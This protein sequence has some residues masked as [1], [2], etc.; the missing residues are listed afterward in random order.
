[1]DLVIE[2]VMWV[3]VAPILEFLITGI[4]VF[5]AKRW[6]WHPLKKIYD[7]QATEAT[8]TRFIMMS[9]PD[10]KS[11][12]IFALVCAVLGFILGIAIFPIAYASKNMSLY[13]FIFAEISYQ[14]VVLPM[15]LCALHYT[16]KK[17]YFF[18]NDIIIK[19]FVYFKRVSFDTIITVTENNYT[20][21][22]LMLVIIYNKKRKVKINQNFVNYDLAKKRFMDMQLIK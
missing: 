3:V 4:V 7:K 15:L 14:V 16:T 5:I 18:E 13:D 9:N 6:K 2:I 19:S 21:I 22:C 8:D 17:I 11:T 1:M 10:I 12:Q 20:K